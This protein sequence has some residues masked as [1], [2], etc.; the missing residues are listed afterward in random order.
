MGVKASYHYE[1]GMLTINI[2]QKPMFLTEAMCRS[3]SLPALT[4]RLERLP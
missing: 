2:L 3:P 1:N 4:R